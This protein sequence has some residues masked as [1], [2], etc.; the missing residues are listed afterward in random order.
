MKTRSFVVRVMI[1]LL[2]S[3]IPLTDLENLLIRPALR[4]GANPGV[5]ARID[6]RGSELRVPEHG[7]AQND[8]GR[9]PGS[10]CRQSHDGTQNGYNA[11]LYDRDGFVRRAPLASVAA[12]RFGS[13]IGDPQARFPGARSDRFRAEP[14]AVTRPGAI[15]CSW[16]TSK[17]RWISELLLPK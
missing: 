13:I 2:L 17:T 8:S 15:Y 3:L 7:P 10:P 16:T 9:S 6:R 4:S 12:S 14:P 1:C 11:L 5:F